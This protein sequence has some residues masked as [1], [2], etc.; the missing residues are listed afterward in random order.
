MQISR[1]SALK[2]I[3]LAIVAPT[4]RLRQSVDREALMRAFCC[5]EGW[6]SRYDIDQP[7]NFDSLTYACDYRHA[8]RAELSN[9]IEEGTRRIP[10]MQK[11]WGEYWH[12]GHFVPFEL[13]PVDS[14][15]LVTCQ[16]GYCGI[17]PLCDDRR[18]SFGDRYPAS[19]DEVPIGYDP[20]DNTYRDP[21][22]P[23]C[24]GSEDF[25]GPSQLIVQGVRLSYSRLKPLAALPGLRVAGNVRQ[26]TTEGPL[27]FKADGFEGMA[28]G[29]SSEA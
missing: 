22:C 5:P 3:A 23:L 18:I 2:S 11:C 21:S 25:S 20:D 7:F 24:R 17:C 29:I 12:P 27:V 13:P 1:R 19:L 10:D 6:C 9:T 15:L 26:H 28:M 16:G 4:V 14:P 8:V